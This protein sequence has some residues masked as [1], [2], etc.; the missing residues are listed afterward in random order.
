VRMTISS[1]MKTHGPCHHEMALEEDGGGWA[2]VSSRNGLHSHGVCM[3][4]KV[5]TLPSRM[6]EE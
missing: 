5:L 1:H 2:L 4:P 6:D 3:P